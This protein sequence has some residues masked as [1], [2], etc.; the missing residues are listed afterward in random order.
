M[1]GTAPLLSL[2]LR[3]LYKDNIKQAGFINVL[4]TEY[5]FF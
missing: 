3:A 2:R 5:I 4:A 1:S